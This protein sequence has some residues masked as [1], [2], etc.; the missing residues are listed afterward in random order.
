LDRRGI[1][2]NKTTVNQ[3]VRIDDHANRHATCEKR[4]NHWRW[5]GLVMLLSGDAL[6][7]LVAQIVIAHISHNETPTRALPEL[8]RA[9]YQA[10]ATAG[11]GVAAVSAQPGGR[12]ASLRKGASGQ[13]VFD[14]HLVCLECGLHMKMLKR[15]LQTVHN[16]SPAQYRE[17]W[18]LTGDYPMVAHQYAA[19][20]SSLAKE[21]GLGKRPASRSR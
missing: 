17:K 16:T 15:H 6:R 9:V 19:L 8:I 11:S 5:G 20:R 12:P 13:T 18:H 10:L 21:S 14:S 2:G 3:H 4:Q 7:R 1:V